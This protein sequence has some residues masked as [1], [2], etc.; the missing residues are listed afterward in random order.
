M[1]IVI[2]P[3]SCRKS[4]TFYHFRLF[5]TAG[6]IK[7]SY[8]KMHSQMA[9]KLHLACFPASRIIIIN[10]FF[11]A[12]P[13][14]STFCL[15]ILSI[16][17]KWWIC[18]CRRHCA[19]TVTQTPEHCSCCQPGDL[20]P[21]EIVDNERQHNTMQNSCKALVCRKLLLQLND[22]TMSWPWV[23]HE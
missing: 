14:V 23:D 4:I 12:A 16:F 3:F 13:P 22:D 2:Y 5:T 18:C 11:V 1:K 17:P 20:F 6:T 8:F 15:P 21:I 9:L 7:I 10:Q 19:V